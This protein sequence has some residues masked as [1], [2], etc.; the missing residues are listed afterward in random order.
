[1][2]NFATAAANG[3]ARQEPTMACFQEPDIPG[4]SQRSIIFSRRGLLLSKAEDD[5]QDK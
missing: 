4:L 3:L 1:M 5:Q 2:L